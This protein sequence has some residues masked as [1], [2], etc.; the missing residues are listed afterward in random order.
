MKKNDVGDLIVC[1]ESH[2][3]SIGVSLDVIKPLGND[4]MEI[5]LTFDYHFA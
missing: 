5:K 3:P 4:I 1:K 2:S